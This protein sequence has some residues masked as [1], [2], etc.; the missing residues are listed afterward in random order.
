ML[1][2]AND[3]WV[4]PRD[5]P[6]VNG[7]ELKPEGACFEDICVPVQQDQDS[8]IFITRG[9]QA[10]FSVSELAQRLRQPYTVDYES[11]VWSFGAIPVSRQRFTEQ[12]M[13]PDFSLPD[14]QGKQVALSDFKGKKIMLLTWASW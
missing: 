4:R 8:A 9:D 11:N 5:L 2:D 10:W 12:G 3:L 1:P 13:A 6:T 14:W 7:F